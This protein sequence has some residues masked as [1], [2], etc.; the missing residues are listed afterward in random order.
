MVLR[1]G[2]KSTS[3]LSRFE[4]GKQN[5]E[6]SN[7]MKYITLYNYTLLIVPVQPL[8]NKVNPELHKLT[9]YYSED[10]ILAVWN[11]RRNR[12]RGRRK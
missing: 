2:K 1:C 8:K 11:E 12:R 5:M 7:F 3:E 4:N 6:F 10:E 9:R